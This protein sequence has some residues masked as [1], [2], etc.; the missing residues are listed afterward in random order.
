MRINSDQVSSN[1]IDL[2]QSSSSKPSQ[3]PS[4]APSVNVQD[5]ASLTNDASTVSALQ[6]Q[7]MAAPDVRQEK[8]DALKQQM[9]SGQYTV[10]PSEVAKSMRE[11]G[12]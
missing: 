7:A 2:Q 1:Q 11:N 5:T 10:D 6:Q 8:V 4:P 12:L 9:A 3:T